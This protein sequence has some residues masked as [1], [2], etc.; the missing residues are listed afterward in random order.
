MTI[1][2]ML[3]TATLVPATGVAFAQSNNPMATYDFNR[4]GIGSAASSL[5]ASREAANLRFTRELEELR[6]DGLAL[7]VRDGGVLTP[8]HRAELQARLDRINASYPDRNRGSDG[9]DVNADGSRRD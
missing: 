5:A 2:S 4:G 1:R 3:F 9:L 8:D 6:K 7:Q